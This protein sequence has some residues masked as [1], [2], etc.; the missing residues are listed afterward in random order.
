MLIV[1]DAESAKKKCPSV[2][3]SDNSS[4]SEPIWMNLFLKTSDGL[5]QAKFEDEQN[6]SSGSGDMGEKVVKFG[7]LR[8]FLASK[9]G[10]RRRSF[11]QSSIYNNIYNWTLVLRRGLSKLL[12]ISK[13]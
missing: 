10:V 6:R 1:Y 5:S 13:I 3:Q 7:C 11:E 4:K 2:C 9:R 12:A 8:G